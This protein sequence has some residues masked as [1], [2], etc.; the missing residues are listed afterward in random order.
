MREKR[1]YSKEQQVTAITLIAS[2]IPIADVSSRLGIPAKTLY[3]WK[4]RS[5]NTEEYRTIANEK[6]EEHTEAAKQLAETLKTDFEEILTL[7]TKSLKK[8]LSE[9]ENSGKPIEPTKLTTIIGTI[10]DKHAL[11]TGGAT[12][13]VNVSFED[14]PV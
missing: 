11:L 3:Q 12:E 10:Y 5:E 9:A 6:K 2:G 13:N 1:T 4:S 8:Q 14:I 7:S